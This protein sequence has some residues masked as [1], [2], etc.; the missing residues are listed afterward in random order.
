VTSHLHN[1]FTL[2][3][4]SLSPLFVLPL[5][6]HLTRINGEPIGIVIPFT[7]ERLSQT[8][9]DPHHSSSLGSAKLF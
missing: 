5:P 6:L 8:L 4:P 3:F 9:I 2:A 7:D 1:P